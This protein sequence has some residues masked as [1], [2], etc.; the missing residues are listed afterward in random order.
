MASSFVHIAKMADATFS[1]D[2]VRKSKS[3]SPEKMSKKTTNTHYTHTH[4]QTED[5]R[6][7]KQKIECIRID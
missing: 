3:Q 7:I 5:V 6:K 4:T 1:H 2:V